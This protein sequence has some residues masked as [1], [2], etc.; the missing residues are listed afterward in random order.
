MDKIQTYENKFNIFCKNY[1]KEDILLAKKKIS[2]ASSNLLIIAPFFGYIMLTQKIVESSNWLATTSSDGKHIYYNTGFILSLEIK[3]IQFVICHEIL[4]LVYGHFERLNFTNNIIENKK[5]FDISNDYIVNLDIKKMLNISIHEM[6]SKVYYNEEFEGYTSEEIYKKLLSDIIEDLTAAGKEINHKNIENQIDENFED[7]ID[8]HLDINKIKYIS[9]DSLI[10]ED[11]VI[12]SLSSPYRSQSEQKEIMD[13]FQKTI[14][15]AKE[16]VDTGTSPSTIPKGVVRIINQLNTPKVPWFRVIKNNI[17]S[18]EKKKNSWS[19]PNRKS[20]DSEIILP[21]KTKS[22]KVRLYASIDA[23][24]SIKDEYIRKFLSEIYSSCRKLKDFELI[25]WTFDTNV[26]NI[27]KY[28]K[29]NLS[30]LKTYEVNG[31]G[32]TDFLC[33]WNYMKSQKIVPEL[34]IMFT[35]GMYNGI[36]GIEKYCNTIYLIKKPKNKSVNIPKS[37]GKSIYYN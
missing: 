34:F 14:T 35:D 37:Y 15:T 5:L 2:L 19:S 27:K 4:H 24:S 30:R 28:N 6:P 12:K 22:K 3:K 36:P 21:K 10:M 13:D 16:I 25:I 31:G 9:D 32:G 26:Y 8:H 1:S 7:T 20:F 11:D 29:N 18:I 33:N 23:S 17:S